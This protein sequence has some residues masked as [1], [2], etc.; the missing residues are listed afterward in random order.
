M[1]Y[2]ELRAVW[3]ALTAPGA[4]FELETVTVRGRRLRGYKHAP[5]DLCSF[6][7]G[8]ADFGERQYIVFKGER[9]TYA[10]AAATCDAL[11]ARL[12]E[13][14]V[15]SGDRVGIAMRNYPEWMLIYWACMRIG[16]VVVGLNAWWTGAEL[17]DA[18]AL[19]RPKIVFADAERLDRLAGAACPLA[20]V[21]A[22]KLGALDWPALSAPGAILPP[23]P[24][25]DPD[26]EA[27]IFFTSGT[28][29]ASKA[30]RLSHRNCVTNIFNVLFWA[31][32]QALAHAG[33]TSAATDTAAPTP[34]ALLTTPLFHV[35]AN[36]CGA[37][38][39]T[40]LGGC[41]VLM[42]RWDAGEALHLIARER[43]TTL[44]GVPVMARELVNHPRFA[45]TDASS[46]TSIG[47]GGAQMQPDLVHR[48]EHNSHHVRPSTGYGMT[49]ASGVIASISGDF[50]LDKPT[51]C[52]P[53]MPSFD[54][55]CVDEDGNE[56]Q[57]GA[58]GELCVRGASV[59]DGY[60]DGAGGLV[61]CLENG[62]LH[63]GDLARVDEH[64]FIHIVDRKKDMVLRGGEN[65]FCAEV[66]SVLYRHPSVAECCV[67][68]IPDE[69]LGEAVAAAV[70]PRANETLTEAALIAHCRTHIAA[71]KAPE[72][73]WLL[74]APIPRNA[75]GKFLKREVRDRLLGAASASEN[76]RPPVQT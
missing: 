2:S 73:I 50:F 12:H 55:K 18:L 25:I 33:A 65:V 35:T 13:I 24:A 7:R 40:A 54:I 48:I 57:P 29:G 17:R 31:Q 56:L 37:H 20:A 41:M 51:S 45:D 19:T 52:G 67:F 9:I 71:F 36:N 53:P 5:H 11:A 63:T 68:A 43:V 69:R 30:A 59:I 32:A 3:A 75:S 4:P 26:R 16:A 70:L 46:L 76:V 28:S 72:R 61:S 49:E 66:E 10:E 38:V 15:R 1:H 21:R 74:S 64:G 47:G 39:V 8:A 58:V 14:G 42:H 44:S 34:V 6:W 22:Q 62:W 27:C 23:A 60:D